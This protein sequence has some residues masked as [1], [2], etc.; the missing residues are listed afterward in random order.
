M[1][2]KQSTDKLIFIF[3]KHDDGNDNH[4]FKVGWDIGITPMHICLYGLLYEQFCVT[5]VYGFAGHFKRLF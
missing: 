3:G 2:Y 4:N 5:S 1:S